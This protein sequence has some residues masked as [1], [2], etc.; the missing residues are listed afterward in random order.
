MLALSCGGDAGD[1]GGGPGASPSS[2][3]SS[4][5]ATSPN[6]G[7]AGPSPTGTAGPGD[8]SLPDGATRAFTGVRP[9]GPKAP[10]NVPVKDIPVHPQSA[11]YAGY[12][13]N[14]NSTNVPER[15]FELN[16]RKY[17]YPVYDATLA[18]D[19]Y[20]V[21]DQNAW[22]NL[23]GT[24]VPF[25]PAW[26]P[27]DGT[28][29][30]LILLDPTTGREWDLWGVVVDVNAKK[31]TIGNGNLC[32]GDYF[33]NDWDDPKT[34]CTGSRG[35]GINYLAMLVRPWEIAQGKIEHALSLP[36]VGT[37]GTTFVAPATKLE[38]PGKA[39]NIP[40]GM[41]FALNVSE[42][43]IDAYVATFTGIRPQL[44]DA[45]RVILVALKDYGWFV[46]DTAGGTAF[47]F[48]APESAASDWQNAGVLPAQSSGG[49][50]L[51]RF[52]LSGFI[53]QTRIA[54]YVP[55]DQYP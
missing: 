53:T 39:G 18:T 44:K 13:W 35:V 36:I 20:A 45:L 40:E 8:A 26:R 9:F 16:F 3:P 17:T 27:N 12:L 24:S 1:S 19:S 14:D 32:P 5:G 28:D 37:S 25:N 31:L 55:S 50:E 46:T 15:D 21:V 52:L 54:A 10:W 29:A 49:R 2:P 11:T 7:G 43:D 30:Q 47:Q 38:H 23:G 34:K 42:Q 51:P 4:V 33:T 22:G 48:E 6:D 41:R